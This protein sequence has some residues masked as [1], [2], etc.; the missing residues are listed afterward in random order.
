M[1]QYTIKLHYINNG[2][3]YKT[4]SNN[5][6]CRKETVYS[7]LGKLSLYF[8]SL[9]LYVI[10]SC[11]C[12]HRVVV[13]PRKIVSGRDVSGYLFYSISL[14]QNGEIVSGRWKGYKA[15]TRH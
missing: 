4:V 11:Y 7:V 12:C 13:L 15:K 10:S 3:N 5:F 6:L 8:T 1:R 14:L 9:L 2:Y